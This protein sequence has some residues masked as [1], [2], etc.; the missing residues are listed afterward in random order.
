MP[1]ILALIFLSAGVALMYPILM[2]FGHKK[3]FWLGILAVL[4]PGIYKLY[5][6]ISDNKAKP[7]ARPPVKQ[8]ND[9]EIKTVEDVLKN[10]N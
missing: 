9:D 2:V 6:F 4:S 1:L 7:S 8:F 5:S 10:W 3:M